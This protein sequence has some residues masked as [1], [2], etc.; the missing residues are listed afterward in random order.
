MTETMDDVDELEAALAEYGGEAFQSMILS[1]AHEDIV[2]TLNNFREQLTA[3]ITKQD[4]LMSQAID[5]EWQT[6][7]SEMIDR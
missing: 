2:Q 4:N 3:R 1:N 7:R 6:L 5:K